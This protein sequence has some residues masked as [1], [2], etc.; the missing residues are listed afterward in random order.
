MEAEARLVWLACVL[1]VVLSKDVRGGAG[2]CLADVP[3]LER[4]RSLRH[5]VFSWPEYVAVV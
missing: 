4:S 3:E 1:L 5:N 2:G